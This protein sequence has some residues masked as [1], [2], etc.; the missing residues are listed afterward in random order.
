MEVGVILFYF[1]FSVGSA[2]ASFSLLVSAGLVRVCV[3]VGVVGF[4]ASF[5][6]LFPSHS[7][8]QGAPASSVRIVNSKNE[9][10]SCVTSFEKRPLETLG[11]VFLAV[12][13]VCCFLSVCLTD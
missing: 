2:L 10:R 13:A 12:A 3:C 6:F 5:C 7:H 11:S 8:E 4:A 1:I 9:A